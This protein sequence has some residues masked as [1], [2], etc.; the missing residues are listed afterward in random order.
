MLRVYHTPENLERL[1]RA[2]ELAKEKSVAAIQI[3]LAYVL[4][5]ASP[6][7]ALVGAAAVSELET[8]VAAEGMRLTR[9]EMEWLELKRD[10]R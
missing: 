2:R 8:S 6:M 5:Q 9:A 10:A 7:I 3:A 1:R 4:N